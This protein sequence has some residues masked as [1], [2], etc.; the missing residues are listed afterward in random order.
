MSDTSMNWHE[1]ISS[2]GTIL[3]MITSVFAM[4]RA[5]RQKHSDQLKKIE[6]DLTGQLKNIETALSDHMLEDAHNITELQTNV[7]NLTSNVDNKLDTIIREL[8]R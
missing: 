8:E 7:K 6:E 5:S 2:V 3:A 1:I 4:W